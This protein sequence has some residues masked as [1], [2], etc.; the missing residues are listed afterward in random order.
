MTYLEVLQRI[1]REL[2]DITRMLLLLAATQF[3]QAG[4][5]L[6]RRPRAK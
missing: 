4:L 1:A 5:I 3:I 6:W 2:D